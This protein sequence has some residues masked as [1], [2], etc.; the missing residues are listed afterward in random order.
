VNEVNEDTNLPTATALGLN[1]A[2]TTGSRESEAARGKAVAKAPKALMGPLTKLHPKHSLLISYMVNGCPHA[3]VSQR[4]R[5]APTEDD[6]DARRCL[7]QNE[8]LRLEEAADLIGIRW[9]HARHLF[10]QTIFQKA[11]AQELAALRDGAKARAM[12]K[13]IEIVENDGDGTAADRKVQLAA[14]SI[15]LGDE[16]GPSKGAGV[17]VTINNNQTLQAGIVVRLPSSA[18]ATPGEVVTIE[19]ETDG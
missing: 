19:A 17:S 9:R 10:A 7:N 15:L 8:P 18:K 16:A 3:Y 4:T 2:A 13:V 12:H 5:A 11:L 6:P 1:E 14:A